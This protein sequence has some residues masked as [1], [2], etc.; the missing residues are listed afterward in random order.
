M[1][2]VLRTRFTEMFALRYPIMSAPMAM[3]SGA[4]IASAVSEAGGLG[5]FGG[6]NPG[7]PT[8]IAE[9]VA[10]VRARTDR[11]FAIGFITPFLTFG[12]PLFEAALAATAPV[13]MFSFSDPRP[14]I[15]Q[16]AAAGA[17]TICQVQTLEQADLAVEAGADVLVAQGNEAGGHNGH[18]GLLPFLSAVVSCHPTI[19]VLAAGGIA[20][21]R[22]LAAVLT[23]GADGAVVGTAFLATPEVIEVDD[24]HKKLIVESDGSDTVF[25][26]AYDIASGLPWPE[27]IGERVHRNRFTDEWSGREDELHQR[28]EELARAGHFGV[29]APDPRSDELPYGQAAG[30]VDAIRP[31]AEVLQRIC[32]HAR[33]ILQ[34]RSTALLG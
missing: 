24:V 34:A 4:T 14:W 10:Q 20:D 6:A 3:H 18:L 1:T 33:E 26:R 16:A 30:A 7:G 17:R 29:R 15:E 25:T 8:W 32:G 23:A 5:A 28:R 13:L 27:T 19:P 9:Q 31:A 11:P 21:G 2:P 12:G 22:T